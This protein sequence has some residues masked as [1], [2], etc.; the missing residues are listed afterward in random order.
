MRAQICGMFSQ[1]SVFPTGYPE[2]KPKNNF[3]DFIPVVLSSRTR[4]QSG[5]SVPGDPG[6][7]PAWTVNIPFFTWPCPSLLSCLAGFFLWIVLAFWSA[8]NPTFL[9]EV[10]LALLPVSRESVI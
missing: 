6:G 5:E 8:R 4:S 9:Q 1:G 3:R 10:L 2:K 7:S